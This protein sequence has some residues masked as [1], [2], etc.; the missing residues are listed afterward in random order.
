MDF[1][2]QLDFVEQWK[3]SL[4]CI[5]LEKS[6]KRV[7]W[8]LLSFNCFDCSAGETLQDKVWQVLCDWWQTVLTAVQLHLTVFYGMTTIFII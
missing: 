5:I 4:I 3:S 1:D 8:Q 6:S 2:K 7:M